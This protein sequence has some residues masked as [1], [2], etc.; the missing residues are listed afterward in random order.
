MIAAR[1]VLIAGTP[2]FILLGED[3][4]TGEDDPPLRAS[5]S[6]TAALANVQLANGSAK[7]ISGQDRDCIDS[8]LHKVYKPIS[9]YSHVVERPQFCQR[10][11]ITNDKS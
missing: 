3:D 6:A 4:Q 9:V 8:S 2:W 7:V 11:L 10:L 5:A 1:V